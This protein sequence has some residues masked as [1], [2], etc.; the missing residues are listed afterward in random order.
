MRLDAID[1]YEA[2]SGKPRQGKKGGWLEL[3]SVIQLM[4][5]VMW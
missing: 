1:R 4:F 5:G 3:G 2:F